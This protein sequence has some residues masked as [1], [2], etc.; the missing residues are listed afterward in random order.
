MASFSDIDGVPASANAFLMRQVLRDEWGFEGF[1]VSDWQSI[2]QLQVHGLTANDRESA[3]EAVSAGVDM[4]MAGGAYIDHLE[5]LVDEGAIDIDV[6]DEAVTRILKLKFRLGLF[7]RTGTRPDSLPPVA[8][9]SALETAYRSALQSVVMLANDGI[10][11]LSAGELRSVAVI[12]PLAEA[13]YEQLGTWVF[14]GDPDISVTPLRALDQ[15]V[16]GQV[17][18]T[19]IR[20][21][22]NSRS[23]DT[24]SFDL[25][26]DAAKDADVAILFLGE[27]S[28]L[29][30]EAHSRA[31]ITLPGAQEDLVRRV[32]Q[33]GKPVIAVILAGRPLVLTNIVSE[34]DAI[35]YAWH[36]GTMGGPAIADLLFGNESPSGK[37]PTTF[38]KSVG[39]VP[40]YYNHKNTGRPPE[41]GGILYIDDIE[42]GARQTSIGMSAFYLDDGFEPLYPFGHGLSYAEFSYDRIRTS[43]PAMTKGESLLVSADLTNT[44]LV[45]AEEVVQLYVRDLVGNVTRPVKELKGFKRV[46]VEPGQTVNVSF[47]LT[48]ND[49]EFYGRANRLILE[50]GD[51]HVWIGGSSATGLRSQ[52]RL[53][54]EE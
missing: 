51:F 23:R 43:A 33:A 49:L 5:S 25:A 1:V 35:L 40:V 32:R 44:G 11:P 48:A 42:E 22:R 37:L 18:I 28:I 24:S 2:Q 39:Q 8:D 16:G 13:P 47:E 3:L 15:L 50:P 20:A 4:E 9:E 29:S 12:G 54:H 10:L 34:V 14:D 7:N 31:D 46:R 45:A 52:F 21:L 26:V 27:E 30:G 19:H 38:P 41:P 53:V 36:P 6:I 17:E